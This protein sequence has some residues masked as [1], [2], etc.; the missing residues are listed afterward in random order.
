[1][2]EPI[3]TQA[4]LPRNQAIARRTA[5]SAYPF[6]CCVVCGLQVTTCLTIAHL[7]QNSGNNDPDNLAF[8][9][10]THHWMYDAG[11]YPIEAIR[12]LRAHWQTTKGVASHKA[13]MKDAGIKAARA[14]QLSARA[15]KAWITRKSRLPASI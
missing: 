5:R 13:R 9:C 6:Q 2:E 7:D 15:R 14:R 1:M 4:V 10:Q 8:M 12:L 3:D 11:L